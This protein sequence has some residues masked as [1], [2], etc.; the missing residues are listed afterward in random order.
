MNLTLTRRGDYAVRAAVFLAEAWERDG[1]SRISDISAAM[2]LPASYTPQILGL[3]TRAGLATA[4]AG[5]AGGYRLARD[6]GSIS[7]LDVVEAAEG[8]LMSTTCILRGGPCHWEGAC[9]VHGA[10]ATASEAFR[11]RLRQTTLSDLARADR[12]LAMRV[13]SPTS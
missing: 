2:A 5:P 1:L 3:L 4:R 12:D 7:L 13:P 10:W 11:E 9:A 6:P 8:R